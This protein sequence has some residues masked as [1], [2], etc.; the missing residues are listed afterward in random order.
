MFHSTR[1][2]ELVSSPEAILN[3]LAKDGGLYV[4]DE[5][6]KINYRDFLNDDYQT[7]ASKILNAFFPE[8]TYQEIKNEI[9]NAYK[10]FDIKEVVNL[11][12]ASNAY[13]LELFHGPTLAFKDLALVVLPRLMKLSKEKMGVKKNITILTATSGDTGGAALNGFRNIPGISIVVLY[14]NG[15]ISPVQEAQMCSFRSENAKVLAINGNF[16]DC[17][18]FVK[19]FFANNKD[20]SLSSANSINIARLAPQIVYYFYSYIYLVKNNIIKDGD[21]INFDVPTGNFGNIFAGFYAK[22]LGLPINNLICAS[23][24]NSVLTD[25]FLNGKYDKKRPFFKTNSPSM[26]ILISSN[27]ERFLYYGT[28]SEAKTKELMEKLSKNGE[29]DFKNPFN[30]FYA[31]STNEEKT[32]EVIKNVYDQYK[33]V[34]DPHT[35]VAY[36]AYKEYVKETNDNNPTVVVSTASPYKFPQAVLSAFGVEEND[37]MEAINVLSKKF[38]LEIPKVLNYPKVNRT[39][40]SLEDSEKYVLDVIKC[41]E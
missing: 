41:F 22:S 6:P 1:G 11:H 25:F 16:D 12:K 4:I 39:V 21:K 13:F 32:L 20:L 5:M 14:P 7:M 10:T 26:D 18:S 23:N 19:E 34:I 8:F 29:Y 37:A 31:Y 38:S 27:L 24:K 28:N 17:Q 9:D 30:Y 3:G 15:G 2:N 35:A 40:V 33:Y 36:N